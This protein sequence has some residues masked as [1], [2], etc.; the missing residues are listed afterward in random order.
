MLT[1]AFGAEKRLEMGF[2]STV[3]G[4]FWK[5][6]RSIREKTFHKSICPAPVFTK[7]GWVRI[8]IPI[9]RWQFLS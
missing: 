4:H 6:F 8:R 2:E 1:S 9:Y 5:V 3:G 7:D